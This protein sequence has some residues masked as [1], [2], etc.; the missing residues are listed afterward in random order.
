MCTRIHDITACIFSAEAAGAEIQRRSGEEVCETIQI[1]SSLCYSIKGRVFP[2]R[3][4]VY[5]QMGSSVPEV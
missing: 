1:L 3:N 5:A 2:A 4:G